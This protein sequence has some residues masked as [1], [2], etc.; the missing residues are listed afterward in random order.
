MARF[1]GEYRY[2]VDPKGRINLPAPFRKILAPGGKDTSFIVTRGF[3]LCLVVYPMEIWEALELEN[4]KLEW[5][6]DDVRY[7]LRLLNSKASEQSFDK[8]GR[9]VLSKERRHWARIGKEVV[10]VGGGLT[11]LEIFSPEV[12]QTYLKG[13]FAYEDDM[14]ARYIEAAKRAHQTIRKLQID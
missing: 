9:I 10:I 4:A 14:D 12:Y 7:Y 3:E 5:T 13:E 8:Q 2:A 11:H 6:D 1:V